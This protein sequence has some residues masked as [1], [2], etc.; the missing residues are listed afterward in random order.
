MKI[1]FI[2]TDEALERLRKL[3]SNSCNSCVTSVPYFNLR[4]YGHDKQIG[5]EDTPEEYIEKLVAIFKEV[6]RVL[7]EDGTLWINIGDTYNGSGKAN[8]DKHIER[9]LQKTN[10]HSSGVKPT[11]LDSLKPKDL[12]GIPWM[13]AFA[14]RADGWYLRQDIIWNKPNPMPE[15]V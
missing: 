12:I 2:Y 9:Y 15:S 11:Y 3:P 10:K 5:L 4:D 14:L 13:L 6:K 1:N 8:N 7:V